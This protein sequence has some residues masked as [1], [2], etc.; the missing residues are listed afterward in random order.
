MQT[1]PGQIT[2]NPVGYQEK[3]P[4]T[5]FPLLALAMF[6]QYRLYNI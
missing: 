3:K 2:E 4:Q 1:M 6:N 5:N